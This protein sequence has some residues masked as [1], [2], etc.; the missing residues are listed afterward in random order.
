MLNKGWVDPH[1]PFKKSW[2]NTY[3]EGVKHV[4]SSLIMFCLDPNS[5]IPKP[6]YW[7]WNFLCHGYPTLM[8]E[9]LKFCSKLCRVGQ[10]GLKNGKCSEFQF[11]ILEDVFARKTILSGSYLFLHVSLIRY[12]REKYKSWKSFWK[13]WNRAGHN[14]A[15]HACLL[16]VCVFFFSLPD[17]LSICLSG[18]ELD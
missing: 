8:F 7:I 11:L 17:A 3:N 5:I 4:P 6:T 14:A 2:G 16:C 15:E 13:D 12:I 10:I 9:I 18:I 1:I